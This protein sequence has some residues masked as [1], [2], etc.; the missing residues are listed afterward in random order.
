MAIFQGTQAQSINFIR[1]LAL[2]SRGDDVK[3]LQ[4]F[5]NSR[6][7]QVSASGPGSIGNETT[8]FGG[9]TKVALAKWQAG[10]GISPA[11]GYFG[12]KSRASV[13]AM[14]GSSAQSPLP[15]TS[16]I[17]APVSSADNAELG[18]PIRLKIPKVNVNAVIKHVGLTPQGAMDAPKGPA[19]VAWFNLGPRPGDSGSA[20][21]S[22]H[23]GRWKTGEGSVFDNL[24]KLIK[25]DKIY[26][27]NEKGE[28]TTFVVR[29]SR[30]YGLNADASDVFGSSD[31]KAHL[32]LITCE[33]VW[34][35][36]GKTY[37]NRLVVFTDKES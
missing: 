1:D 25:G 32:N 24:N 4:Q 30:S 17:L 7:V 14:A 29:E 19:D 5:L 36:V 27:E 8:Y 6:G 15:S 16:P 37:S 10:N 13:A 28:I 34:D 21:I 20:V 26:V 12:P 9:A 23:Y 31:G 18:L 35:K 33:G 11:I 2:G 3:I 22:G